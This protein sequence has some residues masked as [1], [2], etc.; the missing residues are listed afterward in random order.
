MN[1]LRIRK[2]NSREV[3]RQDALFRS[4][5]IPFGV[6]KFLWYLQACSIAL[7]WYY[8]RRISDVVSNQSSLQ[9]IKNRKERNANE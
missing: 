7:A 8:D 3:E 5:H 2:Q 4:D 6:Y 9:K 1:S